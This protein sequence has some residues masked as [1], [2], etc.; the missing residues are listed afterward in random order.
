MSLTRLRSAVARTARQLLYLL[1]AFPSGLVWFVGSIVG[2]STGLGLAVVG[3]GLPILAATLVA[4][5]AA[6]EVERRLAG[7]LLGVEI[8]RAARRPRPR[9][10]R[11]GEL[12]LWVNSLMTWKGVAFL[13][14]KLPAGVVT[15]VVVVVTGALPFL[16]LSAPVRLAAEGPD[17]PVGAIVAVTAL[18]LV[19]TAGAVLLF[20]TVV[21]RLAAVWGR[22][23]RFMLGAGPEEVRDALADDLGDSSLAIAY[24]LPEHA[25][26]VDADGRPVRLP[27]PGSGRSYTEVDL[28]GHR[29]AALVHDEALSTQPELVRSAATA[30]ALGLENERLKAEL[31]ARVEEV[32]ASRSRLVQ[33]GD[34]SRRR[35]ERDLHD[36]AQ[37][38]LVALSLQLRLARRQVEDGTVA[39]AT[40]D[41]SLAE[42]SDALEELRELARGI[43]P[44]VLTDRGL[45]PAVEALAGRL[46]F[47]VDLDVTDERFP[48]PLEATLYFVVAEALT[49]VA[50]YAE[51]THASVR[52]APQDGHVLAEVV[53]DGRGGADA[54]EGSGLRGLADRV[55]AV[56]GRLDVVSPAGAGT[57]VRA[58]VPLAPVAPRP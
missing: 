24:W 3:V 57:V 32:R 56:D 37:Q 47:P 18:A 28:D 43:H 8:P 15:L 36:G 38:R 14:A 49:N 6:A 20:R 19:G 42:L 41:A 29:V 2:L 33:V 27:E 54:A 10:L 58:A 23:A 46:P 31:R 34:D 17:L 16:L 1:L 53:D 35:L 44:A 51:A 12:R 48:A 4:W 55:A 5:M 25:L 39:A 40:I 21:D 22:S 9:G 13:L 7:A 50:K 52:V 26:W 30:A 45:R 11:W